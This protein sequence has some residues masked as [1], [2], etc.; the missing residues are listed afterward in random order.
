MNVFPYVAL[1]VLSV[2]LIETF[3]ILPAHLSHEERWSRVPLRT[4]QDRVC[5][6]IDGI[7]DRTVVPAVSWSVRHSWSTL[8][9][10]AGL[11]LFSLLLVGSEAVRVIL[12]DAEMNPPEN[13]QVD[14]RLPAGTPFGTTLAAAEQVADAAYAMNEQLPGESIDAVS[15]L[16]GNIVSSR[17]G[18]EESNGSHL[19]GVRVHLNERPLRQATPR[20][21][22]GRGAGTSASSRTW[23]GWS[24]RPR[25]FGPGPA[26][27]TR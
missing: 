26:S 22:S 10:G 19:A 14:L 6:W 27:P 17:T 23:S 5:A 15:I 16:A 4:L 7:R 13:V 12:F 8:A 9:A 21:S 1:F 20:R 3:L 2:S 25:A 24:F 11:V 18:R